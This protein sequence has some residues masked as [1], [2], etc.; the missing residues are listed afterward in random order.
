MS[1]LTEPTSRETDEPPS[2]P[3]AHVG[4]WGTQVALCGA[5][6]LGIHAFGE[7]DLC[8]RC[9]ELNGGDPREMAARG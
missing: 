7:Y 4:R 2:R 9:K 6:I 5:E 1:V 3:I 8:L